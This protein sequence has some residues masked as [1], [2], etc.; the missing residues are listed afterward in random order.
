MTITV[1]QHFND[2]ELRIRNYA[3][4]LLLAVLAGAG[5]AIREHESV[6]VLGKDLSLAT[7]ILFAGL[8]AWLLFYFMDAGWYHRLLVGSVAHAI[9][10]E[11]DLANYVP[12]IGLSQRIGKES[13]LKLG[14]VTLHSK[15]KIHLFYGVIAVVLIAFAVIVQ[16]GGPKLSSTS[17][18]VVTA[19]TPSATTSLTSSVN[20]S[21]SS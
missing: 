1:Q 11:K 10:L 7:V 20:P 14:P 19:T 8:I 2:I 3:L 15:H 16:F 9:E 6:H 12:G 13:P 18:S 4:T 17:G 5:L 21:V